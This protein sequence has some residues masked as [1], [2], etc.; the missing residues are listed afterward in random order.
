MQP[1]CTL[2][3]SAAKAIDKIQAANELA[4]APAGAPSLFVG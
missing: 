3:L 1:G 4:L 2:Y